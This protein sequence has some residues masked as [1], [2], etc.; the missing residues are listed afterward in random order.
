M[1]GISIWQLLIIAV[2]VVLLFGTNKLRT[3]GSD[4]GASIKGFKKAIGDDNSTAPTNTTE[5]TN[6]DAD[7]AAKPITDK[8]PEVKAAEE[9]K[10]KEQV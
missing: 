4:L 8:Q 3:L 2:I 7:F 1:G 9:S 10:N 6:H 5:K